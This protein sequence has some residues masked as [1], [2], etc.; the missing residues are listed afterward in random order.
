MSN[1][2]SL[3]KKYLPKALKLKIIILTPTFLKLQLGIFPIALG[4]ENRK[5]RNVLASG[6]WNMSYGRS[7]VHEMLEDEFA[8]Y[9]NSAYAV[10]TSGGGMGIQMVLRALG[11]GRQ[12][13]ILMQVD[14]CSAVPM[15]ALN[16]QTVPRFYDAD[17]TTFLSEISSIESKINSKTRAII[18]THLWGNSDALESLV[19]LATSNNITLIEDCCLAV[20]TKYRGTHVGNMGKVGIFS[21]GSTKPIQAGEGGI[22]VTHDQ[23]LAK[24]LRAMRHWG[25]RTKDFGIRDVRQLSWNGR[26]SEF[27]A[28]VALEQIRN[29]DRFLEI[30][31]GNVIEFVSFLEKNIP[32]LEV[33]LGN[34]DSINEASFSQV[35]LRI[36]KDGRINKRNL[37]DHL[38]R[39]GIYFFDANFE[40]ITTLSMFRNREWENWIDSPEFDPLDEINEKKYPNSYNIWNATGI[41]LSR[42][43]FQSKLQYSKLIKAF[44]EIKDLQNS[45]ISV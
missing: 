15:S 10:A 12:S 41:G 3:L 33:C 7:T 31:R 30:V 17:P 32:D 2:T 42:T 40:P 25:E 27:S 14:T 39:K 6:N 8:K 23:D 13:Q 37:S 4:Q 36:K 43:N 22:I 16:A 34:S 29:F 5:L 18:G 1:L 11:F 20:G 44:T 9:T 38:A 45:K 24:E 26:M 21:F 19:D 35:I 28:A